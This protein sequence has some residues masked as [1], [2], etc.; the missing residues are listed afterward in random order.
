MLTRVS[1]EEGGN[2]SVDDFANYKSYDGILIANKRVSTASGRTT[3]LTITKVEINPVV[4]ASI[5]GRPK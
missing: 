2:I 1:F 5:F 4:D 3:T